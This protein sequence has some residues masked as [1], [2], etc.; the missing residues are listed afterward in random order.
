MPRMVRKKSS[1]RSA[2]K[3]RARKA[4]SVF[5]NLNLNVRRRDCPPSPHKQLDVFKECH[6][7]PSLL[8]FVH[9]AAGQVVIHNRT[10]VTTV[11]SETL[12]VLVLPPSPEC[13]TNPP[14]EEYCS[15]SSE[16]P[17]SH[18]YPPDY[19]YDYSPLLAEYEYCGC[20][21]FEPN[22]QFNGQELP[23]LPPKLEQNLWVMERIDG[24]L[25]HVEEASQLGRTPFIE[26]D[27]L[28]ETWQD[29]ELVQNAFL[30]LKPTGVKKKLIKATG[31]QGRRFAIIVSLL[32]RVRT[33]LG[34]DSY[35]TKRDLFYENVGLFGHQRQVDQ[36]I[37]TM[38]LILRVPRSHLNVIASSRGLVAGHLKLRNE[39]GVVVD[40]MLTTEGIPVPYLIDYIEILKS[41]AQV[42][43]VIEKDATFQ[44]LREDEIC[45]KEDQRCILI[46]GRG[47][48]DVTT[49]RFLQLLVSKL[50]IPVY[51]ITDGDPHGMDI[52][53]M[54]RYG[55]R[56]PHFENISLAVPD[57]RWLGVFPSDLQ[58]FGVDESRLQLLTENDKRLAL[59]ILQRPY[60]SLPMR[61]QLEIMLERNFK[62]EIQNISIIAP[63]FAVDVYIPLKLE[64]N[65]WI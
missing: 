46:T 10:T 32:K 48:A 27:L 5:P 28:G 57:A 56:A 1:G 59:D 53:C 45:W 13:Y 58:Q 4:A 63:R 54:Y 3:G 25:A 60:C 19:G 44:Q 34:D 24:I 6:P 64:Q 2:A 40:C 49:R 33:L 51:I 36:A 22:P 12:V 29:F 39:V 21:D 26:Y 65:H 7:E 42:I 30:L 43:F 23:A 15:T 20:D 8:Q 17:P 61:R 11:T 35:A 38:T 37:D 14:P 31:P 9:P 41:D 62:A 16:Y 47:Y 55:T 50:C 18:S 52:M